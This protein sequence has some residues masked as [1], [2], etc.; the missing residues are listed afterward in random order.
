MFILPAAL[1]L[2]A[3]LTI[4]DVLFRNI[5]PV[6]AGNAIA[7]SFVVAASYSYQFGR[8]GEKSRNYFKAKLK[9]YE[10]RKKQEKQNA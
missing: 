9:T 5:V 8:L 10:A 2:K 4:G 7:G 1:L 3:P 6:I